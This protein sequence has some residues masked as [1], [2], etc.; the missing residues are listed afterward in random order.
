MS[1]LIFSEFS[2]SIGVLYQCAP[3][4]EVTKGFGCFDL[5]V[6]DFDAIEEEFHVEIGHKHRD[7]LSDGIK[8]INK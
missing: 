1:S 5:P 4:E 8:V 7:R 6:L 2:G 3:P